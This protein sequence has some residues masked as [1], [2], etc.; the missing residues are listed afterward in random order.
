MNTDASPLVQPLAEPVGTHATNCQY[1]GKVHNVTT[2]PAA[3]AASAKPQSPVSRR[4]VS[5]YQP[6][7]WVVIIN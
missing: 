4:V 1:N 7:F 3:I 5:F 6:H 2:T